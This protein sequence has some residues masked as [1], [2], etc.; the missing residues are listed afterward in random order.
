MVQLL[1]GQFDHAGPSM[2]TGKGV[3]RIEQFQDYLAH[4]PDI[5]ILQMRFCLSILF[6]MINSLN[7]VPVWIYH[8]G[9]IVSHMVIFTLARCTIILSSSSQSC[10]IESFRNF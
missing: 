2:G 6:F 5:Q 8:K 1:A 10:L 7:V 9:R 3:L 4:L